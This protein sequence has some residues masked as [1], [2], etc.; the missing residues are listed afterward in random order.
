MAF[1]LVTHGMFWLYGLDGCQL[2]RDELHLYSSFQRHHRYHCCSFLLW[3]SLWK[4]L[5]LY[6]FS[7]WSCQSSHHQLDSLTQA[8]DFHSHYYITKAIGSSFDLVNLARNLDIGPSEHGIHLASDTTIG[9]H[10][11]WLAATHLVL[12]IAFTRIESKSLSFVLLKTL[13][14]TRLINCCRLELSLHIRYPIKLFTLP[15]R[16]SWSMK[17]LGERS[18]SWDLV[19]QLVKGV[20]EAAATKCLAWSECLQVKVPSSS[21][22]DSSFGLHFSQRWHT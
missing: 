1:D 19:S 9:F 12:K 5:S 14:L 2:Q 8:S 4:F 13:G 16:T 7:G 6:P 22:C 11:S 15:E 17:G 3:E 21:D 20:A 10:H 18:T